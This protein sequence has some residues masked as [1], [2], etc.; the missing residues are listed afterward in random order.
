MKNFFYITDLSFPSDKAQAVHIF[1]MIDNFQDFSIK[2]SLI[3]PFNHKNNNF[4]K[5]KKNYN[6]HS[7]KK[8]NIYSIFRDKS[9]NS[10]VNRLVFSLKT[11]LFL[12]REKGIILTRSLISSFIF[13]I[14]NINHFLEIH[15]EIKGLTKIL[16]INFNFINSKNIIKIIFISRGLAKF[17][18]FK[19]TNNIILH[20]ACDTRDFSK[21]KP[22]K[23][24]KK[25]YYVG[26]F[27]KGRGIDLIEKLAPLIPDINFFA[28]G[29]RNEKKK[30][31]KNLKF[32][33]IINYSKVGKI[34]NKADLLLMP[35]QTKISINSEN[36]DDDISKFISPLKM[37]EYLATGIPIVSSNIKVLR[38]KLI[39]NNNSILVNNYENVN[40]WFRTINNLKNNF[41]IRKKIH[42]QAL[43]TASSNTWRKRV[44]ILVKIYEEFY[45]Q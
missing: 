25:I 8:I 16:M 18:S 43:K 12:K 33:G 21:K 17:Y 30:S 11:A 23:K 34:L 45:L 39:H 19:K 22:S 14:L 5:I 4:K 40:S 29:M 41:K 27:Y 6:L 13:S 32:F 42:F 20:D 31:T 26:S 36:Y 2:A 37:F 24:I 9:A 38:E 1:K 15:Q 3:C 7:K 35:Y 28:Y 10:F 44:K